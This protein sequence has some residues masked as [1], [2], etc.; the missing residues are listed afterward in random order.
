[1]RNIIF[2]LVSSLWCALWG[3]GLL[4]YFI[5]R[6]HNNPM[7]CLTVA[8]LLLFYNLF[9]VCMF[10]GL[11]NLK[12]K[13]MKTNLKDAY[14]YLGLGYCLFVFLIAYR[15]ASAVYFAP[16]DGEW[17]GFKLLHFDE[18]ICV[19]D[20]M[21]VYYIGGILLCCFCFAKHEKLK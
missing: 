9:G 18:F 13:K 16:D 6:W 19:A 5:V 11:F 2:I 1:M 7:N 8:A 15:V 21:A 14:R 3:Y 12:K 10:Y 17:F 20:W 4:D